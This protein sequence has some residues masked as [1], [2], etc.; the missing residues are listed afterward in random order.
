MIPYIYFRFYIVFEKKISGYFPEAL[1]RGGIGY[2]LKRLIC[3][4][5]KESNCLICF[6]RN[7][8]LFNIMFYKNFEKDIS[9]IKNI[10][11]APVPFIISVWR[12]KFV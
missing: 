11:T 3:I 10:K 8:C 1:I 6:I 4:N 2:T 7:N 9:P 12:K 5:K